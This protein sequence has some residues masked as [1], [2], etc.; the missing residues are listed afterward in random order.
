MGE[1]IRLKLSS[2]Q[3][4]SALLTQISAGGARIKSSQRLRPGD[5]ISLDF[6]LG[7]GGHHSIASRVTHAAQ[8]ERAFTWHC[9]LDFIDATSEV[10]E[11]ITAF[12]EEEQHRRKIGFAMPRN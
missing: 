5:V 8:E 11:R 4:L 7:T 6:N 9:G 12:V 2:G 3:E 10:T 1:P